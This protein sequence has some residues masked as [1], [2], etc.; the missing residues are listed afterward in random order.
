MSQQSLYC[1]T[2][3]ILLSSSSAENSSVGEQAQIGQCKH[4]SL[5]VFNCSPLRT[6]GDFL[7]FWLKLGLHFSVKLNGA[8]NL[9]QP[10]RR[11]PL[12]GLLVSM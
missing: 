1:D 6:R 10:K 4:G 5:I 2:R 3:A 11:I 8:A 7:H 9:L 12:Q